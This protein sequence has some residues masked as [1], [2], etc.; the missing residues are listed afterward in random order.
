MNAIAT[1]LHLSGAWVSGTFGWLLRATWQAA[2][3]AI[4]VAGLQ[5][6]LRRRLSARARCMLWSVVILRLMLPPLPEW[7]PTLVRSLW[8]AREAIAL[9]KPTPQETVDASGPANVA[10]PIEPAGS[11][12]AI[13]DPQQVAKLRAELAAM[14]DVS[15]GV[16]P[17]DSKNAPDAVTPPVVK[18]AQAQSRFNILKILRVSAPWI[19]LGGAAILFLRLAWASVQLSRMVRRLPLLGD[20]V[21]ERVLLDCADEMGLCAA[22]PILAADHLSG[23]A[24]VGLWKPRLLVPRRVCAA[25][26][27]GELRLMFLHEL[28]HVRRRD[29]MVSW[30]LGGLAALH[31]F[32]PLLLLALRRV[33]ADRELACDEMVLA[34]TRAEDRRQ[35][36]YTLLR[37]A[38]RLSDRAFGR[39][40]V[41]ASAGL[42]EILDDKR[43]L[44]QRIIM[45]SCFNPAL[46]S[47]PAVCAGGLLLL[48]GVALTD[49]AEPA[50][51][52][53][54]EAKDVRSNRAEEKE[55]KIIAELKAGG[56]LEERSEGTKEAA[57][58]LT[59]SEEEP[60]LKAEKFDHDRKMAELLKRQMEQ[61]KKLK[62]LLDRFPDGNADVAKQQKLYA[63]ARE[64]AETYARH[65][66]GYP[67]AIAGKV[68][69]GDVEKISPSDDRDSDAMYT[70]KMLALKL[71]AKKAELEVAHKKL[72]RLQTLVNNGTASAEELDDAKLQ[73][74]K[75]ESELQQAQLEVSHLEQKLKASQDRRDAPSRLNRLRNGSYPEPGSDPNDANK[76]R[77]T[78]GGFGRGG[79]G[80]GLGGGS[81]AGGGGG[82]EANEAQGSDATAVVQD[83]EAQQLDARTA[84]KLRKPL[85][86]A[87]PSNLLKDFVYYV[88]DAA[89]VD[90]LLDTNSLEAVGISPNSAIAMKLNQPAP[91]GQVL[92][93]ALRVGGGDKLGY[94]IDHG[95]VLVSSRDRLSRMT[96]TRAYDVGEMGV[97]GDLPAMIRE[98]I[99]P[100]SWREMGGRGAVRMFGGKLLVT[101]T[102]PNLAQIEKLLV[103]LRGRGPDKGNVTPKGTGAIE[104]PPAGPG[105]TKDEGFVTL[106]L[107]GPRAKAKFETSASHI[108]QLLMAT[109]MYANDNKNAL[110]E[111]FPDDLKPYLGGKEAELLANPRAPGKEVGYVYV[112]P[113]ASLSQLPHPSETV[114]MYEATDA[115]GD[116]LCVG[117]ADGHVEVVKDRDQFLKRMGMTPADGKDAGKGP[118]KP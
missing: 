94:A 106:F 16:E 33:R 111:G 6:L 21:V 64:N 96:L 56:D 20:R 81:D 61:E 80:D 102:A 22:P 51:G 50:K 19:W 35:Y 71:N 84:E 77:S 2:V 60:D 5:L 8:P 105:G 58:D 93:W 13:L 92:S 87:I 113:A 101:Q 67:D 45:I 62:E 117:F 104:A 91:A 115:W 74:A 75:L 54:P 83:D 73:V 57:E 112:R 37:L 107:S 30:L 36:G 44:Q 89:G 55:Q 11:H 79:S 63:E 27:L 48:A 86:L 10:G 15:I 70:L 114:I 7:R 1:A 68:R 90:V 97:K 34:V 42:V 49:A 88:G 4:L 109:I 65:L 40:L 66:Q 23:P 17:V 28:A 85:K 103:L 9:N 82:R 38:E 72:A 12:R 99:S 95:A 59:A 18:V 25:F 53:T 43:H 52:P 69:D 24:V 39:L 29:V 31:W 76:T 32:N 3:L 26:G 118:S 41:P 78:R 100:E 14:P 116:G 98:I 110:P 46:R 108:R 47:W